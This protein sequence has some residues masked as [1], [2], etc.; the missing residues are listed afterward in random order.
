MKQPALLTRLPQILFGAFALSSLLTPLAAHAQVALGDQPLFTSIAV[1][2]NLLLS[3]SVE[4]PTALS[5]AYPY[6]TNPYSPATNYL[7]YF[8][9]AKCYT[10]QAVVT[11]PETPY[12]QSY[13]AATSHACTTTRTVS[14][15]SG[16][17]LN[18][19][20]MQTI[21][22]FRWALT[23]GFR[24]T[25]TASTT[26]LERAWASGQGGSGETPTKTI[27]KSGNPASD[28][29]GA[30][31]FTWA[32]V[33]SRVWGAGNQIWVSN[34]SA[35]SLDSVNAAG[36]TAYSGQSSLSTTN[37]AN[38][39]ATYA[40]NV[41][42]RVC[43]TT[44]N[45]EA[46][47]ISY[48]NGAKP[49]GLMQQYAQKMRYAAFGYL[50]DGSINRDG[51]VLRA[52]MKYIAPTQPVPGAP[53]ISNTMAEWSATD[54]TFIANPNPTDATN[55]AVT[56]SGVMN[57]LNQFGQAA[58]TY[59]IYDPVS[60]LFYAGI[61]Y[62]KNL[63]NVTA[64]TSG[65]TAAMIDGFPVITAWNDPILYSCQKNFIVG[66]GDVNTHADAN[67]PGS[68]LTS[69]YER[70]ADKPVDT[71]V[72]VQTAT[73]MVGTLEGITT[74]ALRG[75]NATN[76]IAGLA[77][78]SHVKDMRPNDF[79]NSD[80]TTPKTLIQTVSTYW[81]D[82]LENQNYSNNNQYYLAA[83]YG[84]FIIPSGF[85]PYAS[86]NAKNLLT[87]GGGTTP[88]TT[89]MWHT[90][91]DTLGSNSRPDN[92]FSGGQADKMVAGL[93]NAFASIASNISG[94][95]T[96]FSTVSTKLTAANNISYASEYSSSNWTGNLLASTITYDSSGNASSVTNWFA[97]SLL[98][99]TSTRKIVTCCTTAG[100]AF[101]FQASNLLNSNPSNYATFATVPGVPTASQSSPN[102]L[103][104]LR[105]SQTLE[106]GQTN[107]VYRTRA[108]L[109]GDI[110]GSKVAAVGPPDSGFSE[111]ANPGYKAFKTLYANR[112]TVAYVGANDG[113]LHAFDGSLAG[114]TEMFAYIPSFLY[115][116]S[117]SAPLTGLASLGSSSFV[118]HYFVDGLQQAFDIDLNATYQSSDSS[119]AWS[120]VLIGGLG[121]G[122][123]G[124]YAIDVTDPASWTTET[125]L[126]GKVLWE[127]TDSRM[128]YSYGPPVVVK[129]KKYGWTVI[130]TSGYNNSDGNGYLFFVNPKTGVL[131]EA[132]A[133]GTG[134][135]TNQT[136]LTY[137]TAFVNNFSDSTAD[138]IYAGD[139]LGN[140][141]RVDLTTSTGTYAAPTQLA[142]LKDSRGNVQPVT[143]RPLI[144]VQPGAFK[145]YVLIGTGRL[146]AS[147]DIASPNI[148]SFYAIADGNATKFYTTTT[149]PSGVV[150]PIQ[151]SNM[152][153]NTNLLS[154]I[155]T[156]PANPMGWYYDLGV[157]S[158]NGV[159]ER[160]IINPTSTNGFVAFASTTPNGD[161]CNPS[162]TGAVYAVNFA[163]GITAL[164]DATGR[165]VVSV[166]SSV[167]SNIQF[168]NVAGH[169][170][171]QIGTQSVGNG[172]GLPAPTTV[173][174]VT[175]A[176]VNFR[177]VNWR[178]L[179][180]AD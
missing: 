113:M 91:T 157:S 12:F 96:A 84:G 104:Y 36:T 176:P 76:F 145:R 23:G 140:V 119:A 127:F 72:N 174:S 52:N 63:G 43:D 37:P 74:T 147:Q 109:L 17:W 26:V 141:W 34:I 65:A 27:P 153:A 9:P 154:G 58:H 41:R 31:P 89:T 29:S 165:S 50:N 105:G 97:Q 86:S 39:N 1:P 172:S 53:S 25:D 162:G 82:V 122:G 7:G 121:K 11:A 168:Y 21:D 167:I 14:L 150:F 124:Y 15:W 88:L 107:G 20:G 54:G 117:T 5:W 67:L 81:I 83:K 35:G 48:G 87:I 130:F 80:G 8:D 32:S 103:A 56:K 120:S 71:T 46:N 137:A 131:L 51:G 95:T 110:V 73:A 159:A 93:T 156:A 125:V 148:Q 111:S 98:T 45:L 22:T 158:G 152:V 64:Y 112:K 28:V 57:Y 101:P 30:T 79:P 164:V 115:G 135:A 169:L 133:T 4:Y 146:L 144:E 44:V 94:S 142:V 170:R 179:P 2:G 180:T 139:L 49:E 10:Y 155:G 90:N 59:K 38:T 160:I 138:A 151:R 99:S 118:H 70:I 24:S 171:L 143:T 13:S 123:K 114:G 100:A 16:N 173:Q 128:G 33:T 61:R 68:T 66:I 178:E 6:N 60:E 134:S 62:F 136:G 161:V 106:I 175:E 18:W 92:Y 40:L 163:T 102:Y 132:V 47:C 55:S 85:Q 166:A 126:S 3:L 116:S 177:S 77:Y 75:D 69:S 129:T 78:D 149:L 108:A 42:V 19:A